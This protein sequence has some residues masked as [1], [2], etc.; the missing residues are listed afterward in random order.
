MYHL[1]LG[2]VN[3]AKQSHGHHLVDLVAVKILLFTT[4]ALMLP[5]GTVAIVKGIPKRT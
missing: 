2:R 5:A 4:P 1:L 3:E